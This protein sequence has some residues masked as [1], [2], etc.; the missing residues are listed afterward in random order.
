MQQVNLL[1]KNTEHELMMNNMTASQIKSTGND[2]INMDEKMILNLNPSLNRASNDPRS[3]SRFLQ[4]VR[5]AC[6]NFN[7]SLINYKNNKF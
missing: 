7:T 5:H 1:S 2:S 3:Q 6:L 4:Q